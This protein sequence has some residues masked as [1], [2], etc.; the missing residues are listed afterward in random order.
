MS[1]GGHI[2]MTSV[3]HLRLR[4]LH[5]LVGLL[6]GSFLL[7]HLSNHLAALGGVDSHIAVMDALRLI[8]R[9]PLVEAA[10]L[11]AVA[12]QVGL[13]LT[14]L[15]RARGKVQGWVSRLQLASGA[16]LAF[17]LVVHISAVLTGRGM[18]LDTNFYFAA[19]G[20]QKL[21]TSLFFVPYYFLAV[22][23]IFTHLGCAAYWV[24]RDRNAALATGL[25]RLMVA[26]GLIASLAISACLMGLV[27][28]FEVPQIYLDTYAPF[29]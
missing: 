4:R 2:I 24:T 18:G 14:F 28:S 19:A 12:L 17:F 7:A 3:A 6:I 15:W 22:L 29:P 25:L 26:L 20:Y 9:H 1:A 8:Y 27:I 23:A 5:G 10:L 11:A 21:S 16:Y 13:G